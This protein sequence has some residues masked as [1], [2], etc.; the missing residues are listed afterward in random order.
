M[1]ASRMT[2][3]QS[4]LRTS[5]IELLKVAAII[6]IVCN[7]VVQTLGGAA[8]RFFGVSDYVLELTHVTTDPKLF[9]LALLKYGGSLGNDLFF[10]CSAWF[11][12]DSQKAKKEKIVSMLTDTFVIS[13][14]FLIVIYAVRRGEVSGL[15]ILKSIYPTT[16]S[17]NW[18][19]TCYLILYALHPLL[20]KMIYTHSQRQLLRI[21]SIGIL[22]YCVLNFAVDN[23]LEL[24]L[25]FTSDL[26]IWIVLYCLIAYLK[27]YL[28]GYMKNVKANAV[29]F[30]VSMTGNLGLVLLTDLVGLRVSFFQNALPYWNH[31]RSP[32][33]IAMAISAFNIARTRDF[34]SRWV[35]Y[36]SG[37]S[38]LIYLSHENI[39]FRTYIRPLMWRFI[40]EQYGYRHILLWVLVMTIV[41]FAFGLVVSLLYKY[42]LKKL[43]D[44]IAGKAF[45]VV[46]KLS[47]IYEDAVM[48]HS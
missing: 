24:S 18:Y 34:Y 19:I 48:K 3:E 42:T 4:N 20:N 23:I 44:K 29:V 41:V 25:F 22:M 15:L 31:I 28:P 11:L 32:F 1:K 9:V 21:T 33:M 12:L 45:A 46:T 37:L 8:D 40:Y 2:I 6:L 36:I 27:L 17:N 26:I 38:M 43:S 47:C 30:V 35:N 16:F 13:I 39:L 10:V 7:H 5:G 14:L